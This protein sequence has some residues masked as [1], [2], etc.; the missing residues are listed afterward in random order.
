[1]GMTRVDL[2]EGTLDLAHRLADAAG[3]VVRRYFR[4]RISV[5]DKADD[6]PVTVADREAEAVMRA[7][8]TAERPQ[9]GLIGEEHGAANPDAEWVW[10]LDPIDGTKSFI[11]GMPTFG[12]L[13]ALLHNGVPVLGII[14]QPISR[15]RWVGAPG[16][17]TTLNGVP[18]SVRDCSD[19]SKAVLFTTD[20]ALFVG[21]DTA[22][23]GRLSDAAKLRRYSADCYAYGLLSAGFVDVVC[24]AGMKL[25]DFAAVVPVILGAGGVVTDWQGLP[26]GQTSDGHI[27]AA[28]DAACHAQALRHLKATC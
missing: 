15:E 9:D 28:G 25:H 8:L 17:Q 18:V 4:T 11:T 22:A 26:L 1:M 2:P 12:T 27:L 20:P 3:E 16:Q 24:E 5:D 14:D 13:I 10:V 21:E 7:L 19:L 6:S 23:W